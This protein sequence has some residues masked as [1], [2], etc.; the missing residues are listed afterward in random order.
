EFPQQ[1]YEVETWLDQQA[2]ML[3]AVAVELSILN[4][5]LFLTIAVAGFGILAI[6]FMIV[7]EKTKDIGILKSLGASGFGIM[8]IFLFY[9]LAL[10]IVGAGFGLILGLWFVHHIQN[11][12]HMLSKIM[13]HEV[14]DPTIYMFHQVPA[15]VEPM[16]VFWI[17]SGAVFI[18]VISGILPAI[19][20]ARL[21]PVDALRV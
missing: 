1:L 16:T 10:G 5:L 14:F 2:P 20:A 7:V 6:F 3:S 9:S 12:A 19:R 21:K 18:A 15:I 13:G 4:V 11:I 17:V 8:Q